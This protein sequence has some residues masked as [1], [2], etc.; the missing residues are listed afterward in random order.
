MMKS[1]VGTAYNE[2]SFVRCTGYKSKKSIWINVHKIV[3]VKQEE[4]HTWIE[5]DNGSNFSVKESAEGIMRSI[6]RLI[7]DDNE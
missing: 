6:G 3:Y 4:D 7:Y 1:K 5:A 2:I